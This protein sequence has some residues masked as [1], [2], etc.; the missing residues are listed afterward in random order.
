MPIELISFDKGINRKK[1]QLILTQGEVYNCSGFSFKKDGELVARDATTV[2]YEIDSDGTINGV[3]RYGTNLVHSANKL[4]A[5]EQAYFNYIYHRDITGTS[6]ANITI[7]GGSTR[8]RF[9]D[10]DKF[11][12]VVDE[13]NKKALSDAYVYNWGIDNPT[14]APGVDLGAAGNPDGEYYCYYT[15][16]VQFPNEKVYETGPSPSYVVTASSQKLSW[17][18]PIPPNFGSGTTVQTRLYRTVSGII[19]YVTSLTSDTTSYTDN[20]LDATIQGNPILST[21]DYGPPPV[22][23]TDVAIHLQRAFVIKENKLYYTEPYMPWAFI[24]GGEIVVSKDDENLTGLIVWSEQLYIPSRYKWYRLQGSNADTW[25]IKQTFTDSGVINKHTLATTR[26]GIPG[27]WYDGIYIFDGATNKNLS[28]KYLG[29]QFFEDIDDLDDCWAY[30]DGLKYYFYYTVDS[31]NQCV[32]L[33]FSYYP[34][35]RWYFDTPVWESRTFYAETGNHYIALDG[36]EYTISGTESIATEMWTGDYAFKDIAKRK[37][38]KY[39]W[40][41]INTGGED[42]TLTLY[43]DGTSTQTWTLNTSARVRKREETASWKCE[44]YRFSL[45]IACSESSAI[46]IYAPWGMDADYVG[47]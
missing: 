34:D 44:G 40:Y 15:W 25:S 39:L 47:V 45:K 2:S 13:E 7:L 19:Y 38:L 42:V 5:G 32:V 36:Y 9:A 28:E 6:N 10:Y 17:N 24:D 26:F 35:I 16:Y 4:C 20:E 1:S 46:T 14:L 41:D 29:K 12:F 8:P 23:C 18:V 43:V 31:V 21:E 37:L 30:F 22:G 11:I 3:H 27:L 33:D